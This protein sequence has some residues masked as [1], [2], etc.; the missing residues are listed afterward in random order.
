MMA[1]VRN[2][3]LRSLRQESWEESRVIL[4]YIGILLLRSAEA[5]ASGTIIISGLYPFQCEG[6]LSSLLLCVERD[7]KHF[8]ILPSLDFR[9]QPL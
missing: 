5:K 8:E 6:T 7:G 2:P 9:C 1:F 4:G 3:R